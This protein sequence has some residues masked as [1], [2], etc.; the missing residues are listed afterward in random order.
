MSNRQSTQIGVTFQP[1]AEPAMR[2]P[3]QGSLI[4]GVIFPAVVIGLELISHMCADA[5]FDPM[6]TYWHV[7]AVSLVP[8]SNLLVW[9]HLQDETRRTPKWFAFA[10]GVAIAIA[11]F[12]ALLFLPLLLLDVHSDACSR[13]NPSGNA[14]A[15]CARPRRWRRRT[16]A[17]R[18]TQCVA[19]CA[20]ARR[21]RPS[22]RG[23]T[24]RDR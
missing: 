10:N 8:A 2:V 11:G 19:R 24:T 9:H 1:V 3:G 12:Y 15:R 14:R 13:G 21:A 22:T 18:A 5:F 16:V 17:R 6:P 4:F 23:A 7:A 20:R